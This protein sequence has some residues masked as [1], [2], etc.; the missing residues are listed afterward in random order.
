MVQCK[1]SQT[2][3]SCSQSA[4]YQKELM[5]CYTKQCK[6][7][8]KRTRIQL[9]NRSIARAGPRVHFPPPH[10]LLLGHVARTSLFCNLLLSLEPNRRLAAPKTDEAPNLA[11][12]VLDG[13]AG[14]PDDGAR[15]LTRQLR[16]RTLVVEMRE[17]LELVVGKQPELQD[18]LRK[19]WVDV[20]GCDLH[21]R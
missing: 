19:G 13:E 9:Q 20:A 3:A 4:N 7:A 2:Y 10:V 14:I 15:I 11:T 8:R 1:L 12:L 5:P 21:E 17:L 18:C 16:R 6:P